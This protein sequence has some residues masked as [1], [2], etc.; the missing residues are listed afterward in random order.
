MRSRAGYYI[1]LRAGAGFIHGDS[2]SAT[3]ASG[4]VIP[5]PV[6]FQRTSNSKA[7]PGF[8]VAFEANVNPGYPF[9]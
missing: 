7:I 2:V 1:G 4:L 9:G 3:S 8:L 6:S 5:T